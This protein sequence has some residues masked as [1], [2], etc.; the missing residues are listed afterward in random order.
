MGIA[1]I[2]P[3]IDF[4]GANLGKVTLKGSVP[5]RGL[6][7]FGDAEVTGVGKSAKYSV[8]F[9]PANTTQ[10]QIS[11]SIVTG[12]LYASIDTE[13]N[14]SVLADASNSTVVIRATSLVDETIFAEKTVTVTYG[15]VPVFPPID[16][17][18]ARLYFNSNAYC[19]TDIA[20]LP[21]DWFKIKV[22]FTTTG[23]T[24][25]RNVIAYR[26]SSNADDDSVILA[27]NPYQ[28][29]YFAFRASMYGVQYRS[30]QA[31]I[32]GTRYVIE[33]KPSGVVATP[34]LGNFDSVSYTFNNAGTLAI[35]AL[36]Y[37]N[38]TIGN[39]NGQMDIFAIEIYSS[40]NR[41]KHRLM[42]QSDLTFL[43]EVTQT[44]YSCTGTVIYADDN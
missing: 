12:S 26:S 24:V 14:L 42:P 6:E 28:L 32:Q 37:A 16:D 34:P 2:V 29:G 5:V 8:N 38:N 41:L 1:L 23:T 3:D 7:I 40:S 22:A 39:A 17:L 10:R 27:G 31:L 35:G 36:H 19:L 25:E 20:P 15:E 21:G 11:W 44:V 33:A 18:T 4:S 30:S 9:T 13:G 43:D